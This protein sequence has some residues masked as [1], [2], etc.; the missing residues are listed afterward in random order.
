MSKIYA[1]QAVFTG[2]V[3]AFNAFI[4]KKESPEVSYLFLSQEARKR[5]IK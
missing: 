3:I 5:K 1:T 4:R 2:R